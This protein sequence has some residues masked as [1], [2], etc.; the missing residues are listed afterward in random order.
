MIIIPFRCRLAQWQAI[1]SRLEKL[2]DMLASAQD[3]HDVAN[4]F[5]CICPCTEKL[6]AENF[7]RN[8]NDLIES[9]KEIDTRVNFTLK[10]QDTIAILGM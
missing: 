9:I 6:F 4:Q 3:I 7:D 10:E 2:L 1:M 8:S 5:C